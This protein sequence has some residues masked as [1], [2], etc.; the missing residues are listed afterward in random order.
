MDELCRIIWHLGSGNQIDAAF[1]FARAD[2]VNVDYG[3][4]T[5]ISAKR[6]H[7][8]NSKAA[9]KGQVRIK[10][11]G[12]GDGGGVGKGVIEGFRRCADTGL[13]AFRVTQTIAAAAA[14]SGIAAGRRTCDRR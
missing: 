5:L 4:N 13:G 6:V 11:F 14:I 7:Q 10:D 12:Q 3:E 8:P 2:F 1:V 9:S